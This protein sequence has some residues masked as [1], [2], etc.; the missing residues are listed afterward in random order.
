[1]RLTDLAHEKLAAVIRAGDTAIDASAGNG[2][3]TMFLAEKVG[4]NGK[5]YAF[6]IQTKAIAAT[7]ALLASKNIHW[8]ELIEADH[9]DLD[10]HVAKNCRV[11]AVV[12]NLGYLP[13]GD[14][15]LTTHWRSTL[16]ALRAC[17]PF[18]DHPAMISILAY[19]GHHGGEEEYQQ[20]IQWVKQLDRARYSQ[21]VVSISNTRSPAPVLI[22]LNTLD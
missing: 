12:F 20:I 2:F 15:S 16:A 11:R 3:D 17:L 13:K 5:V 6:D 9:A 7:R 1:M 10:K 19:R 18:L 22:T 4:A 14:K 21:Q 8:V